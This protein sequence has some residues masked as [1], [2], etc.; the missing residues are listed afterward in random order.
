MHV[1]GKRLTKKI[2]LCMS[3]LNLQRKSINWLLIWQACDQEGSGINSLT[4]TATKL[5]RRSLSTTHPDL[6]SG[7]S[8]N[9]D[10]ARRQPWWWSLCLVT[11]ESESMK[12]GRVCTKSQ[13]SLGGWRSQTVP[14]AQ[15]PHKRGARNAPDLAAVRF[16]SLASLLVFFLCFDAHL[17]PFK[18][19]WA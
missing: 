19:H 18:Q 2:L 8:E 5:Q 11:D 16:L 9:S 15:Q 14:K 7:S 4:K 1:L 17:K 6:P 10:L 12:G 3:R 13:Q